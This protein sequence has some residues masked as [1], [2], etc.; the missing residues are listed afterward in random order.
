MGTVVGSNSS[1]DYDLAR[2]LSLYD[3]S[4]DLP[5]RGRELWERIEP[6]SISIAREFWTRY[7]RSPELKQPFD[8]SRVDDHAAKI[9]PYFAMKF[10]RV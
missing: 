8:L 9:Q 6:E 1:G 3:M 5:A 7:A 4:G 10:S 2:G